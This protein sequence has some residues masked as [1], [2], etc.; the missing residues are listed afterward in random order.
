MDPTIVHATMTAISNTQGL[1]GLYFRTQSGMN[2]TWD[3]AC[4]TTGQMIW[5]QQ[6]LQQQADLQ[7]QWNWN[8]DEKEEEDSEQ[9]II[10]DQLLEQLQ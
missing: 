4:Y 8:T 5:R 10:E 1:L 3:F 9:L 7:Q 2:S 6:F